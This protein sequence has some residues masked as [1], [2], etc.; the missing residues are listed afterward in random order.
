MEATSRAHFAH[1]PAEKVGGTASL[2]LTHAEGLARKP[3][4]SFCPSPHRKGWG[5]DVA[6]SKPCRGASKEA[7][8]RAHFAYPPAEKVGETASLFLSHTKV[9]ARKP[10][11]TLISLIP[12]PKTLGGGVAF[13]KSCRGTSKEATSRSHFAHPLNKKVGG[14]RHLF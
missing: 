7:T 6:F 8:S 11:C 1:P 4:R 2:F 5:D 3:P 12:S 13:S 14:W 10:H 9:L